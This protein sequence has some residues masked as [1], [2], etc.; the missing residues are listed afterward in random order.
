MKLNV[1]ALALTGAFFWGVGLLL[2][3][4]WILLLDGPSAD[5]VFLAKVY[6]GYSLTFTGSLIGFAWG[7]FDGLIGGAIFGWLYNFLL[8]KLT[9]G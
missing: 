6:R 2:Y 9:D 8:A 4:W 1:K 7:F 3:T 5:P